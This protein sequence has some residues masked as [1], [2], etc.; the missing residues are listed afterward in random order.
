MAAGL[1]RYFEIGARQS[2][3]SRE[4]I[5]GINAFGAMAYV[6]VVNPAVMSAAGLD[7][8]SLVIATI[9]A[10]AVGTLIMGLWARLPVA[11]APGVASNV[12]F[13]QIVVLQMGVS[14]Q[15]AFTMVLMGGAAFTLLSI[16]RWRERIVLAFPASVRVG[17]Q[18][19]IG[20]FIAHIGL[21]SGGLVTY[22]PRG[23]AFGELTD[24]AVL[25]AL[26]GLL[27]VLV[28]HVR[29]VP[30]GFLLSIVMLTLAGLF[31]TNGAGEPLTRL[32]ASIVDTPALPAELFFAFDFG[33]F[34]RN[35][36]LV[37]PITLYFFLSDFFAATATLVGVTR[38]SGLMD[39]DGHMPRA[40]QAY[41]ADGLAS[42]AG[43]ALGTSTV[44]TY[45]ESAVGVEAGARTGLMAVVVAMLFLACL[46]LWPLAGAIPTLAVA[47][48]LILVGVL[49]FE[50]IRD[51]DFTRPEN[52]LPPS[53]MILF[54]VVTMNIV[55][56]LAVGCFAYTVIALLGGR[57]LK[58]SPL[59]WVLNAVFALYMIVTATMAG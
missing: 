31:V 40:R 20:L 13:A 52:A 48:T 12:I 9:L 4:V 53:L 7:P 33:E 26:A 14:Y 28:L 29:R 27:L 54:T 23:T 15:T 59:M 45:I 44:T 18:C 36:W 41:T 2:S 37:L 1:D 34:I 56:G 17:M 5:G 39:A 25:L 32:P 6:I 38:R 16:T 8:H 22:G 10:S 11:L 51:L 24:P 43:A 58:V 3:L 46:F 30:A 21:R 42:M 57:G 19:A 47:P 49:M 55:M 35:I 50:G